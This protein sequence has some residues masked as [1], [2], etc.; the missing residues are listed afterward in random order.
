MNF[1]KE[2]LD[3][4]SLPIV[5]TIYGLGDGVSK[6]QEYAIKHCIRNLILSEGVNKS[7]RSGY[8]KDDILIR[9]DSSGDFFPT[10]S[11][12]LLKINDIRTVSGATVTTRESVEKY[13]VEPFCLFLQKDFTGTTIK[14]VVAKYCLVSGEKYSISYSW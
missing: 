10:N 13:F 8:K 4:N 5:I 9:I 11:K 3:N 1:I 12:I 6:S 2:V 7:L 14:K